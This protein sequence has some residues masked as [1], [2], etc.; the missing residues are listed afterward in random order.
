MIINNRIRIKETIANI[1]CDESL[2]NSAIME[3]E[4][5]RNDLEQYIKDHNDFLLSLIPVDEKDDMPEIAK[6]MCRASREV[7]VGPMAAVAGAI[8]QFAIKDMIAGGGKFG[9]V[10]NGGD[11]CLITDQEVIIGIYSGPA[12]IKNVGFKIKPGKDILGICT[13]SGVIGHSLSFGN[14]HA[15]TVFS[16][17]TFL[18][19]AVATA[20]CNECKRKDPVLIE[21]VLNK[22]YIDKIIGAT[23]IY[24]D[25]FGCIGDIPETCETDIDY[26][27]IAK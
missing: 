23:V 12:K 26:K 11:I 20:L 18:A 5:Q 16:H 9:I 22:Y 8:S 6:L 1:V 13:S 15:V 25:Y 3:I 14:A 19:D 2:Y 21:E 24:D 27:L 17:D 4:H 10:D 7:N